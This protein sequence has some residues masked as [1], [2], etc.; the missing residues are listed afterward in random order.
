MNTLILDRSRRRN[1]RLHGEVAGRYRQGHDV[2]NGKACGDVSR[3]V[4]GSHQVQHGV[5]S[6]A[7]SCEK[8]IVHS[9]AL[10]FF[11]QLN[12]GCSS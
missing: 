2:G 8:M 1:R 9:N 12:A 11:V 3:V 7:I 4:V 10:F 5:H 6:V